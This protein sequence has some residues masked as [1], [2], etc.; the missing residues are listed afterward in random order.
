[1]PE[2]DRRTVLRSINAPVTTGTLVGLAG[3]SQIIR[4]E[5]GEDDESTRTLLPTDQ[6]TRT[7]TP[8]AAD[9]M[10]ATAASTM[11]GSTVECLP[12]GADVSRIAGR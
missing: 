2:E 11:S 4:V 10:T 5:A 6:P 3:C 8:T 1:M 9:L 12:N 7:S